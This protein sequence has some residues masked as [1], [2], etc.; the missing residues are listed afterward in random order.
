MLREAREAFEVHRDA[1]WEEEQRIHG[2]ELSLCQEAMEGQRKKTD[3][4][5]AAI[6]RRQ[7]VQH[8][9]VAEAHDRSKKYHLRVIAAVRRLLEQARRAM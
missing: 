7:R 8:E 4:Q 9:R 2:H 6:H 5:W 1:V 3:T